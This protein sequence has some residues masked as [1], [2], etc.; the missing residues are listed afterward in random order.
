VPDVLLCERESSLL[1][2]SSGRNAAIFRPLELD[3]EITALVARSA[4][5][6][7]QLLGSRSEWLR[8]A[9][10]LFVARDSRS[11]DHLARAA[12]GTDVTLTPL[13]E[14]ELHE[15][16]PLLREGDARAGMAVAG[17]G[18]LDTHA[19]AT[20]LV[21]SF[22]AGGGTIRTGVDIV[23]IEQRHARVAGVR[24][25]S[26]ERLAC[27]V[28]VIA[29]GA[30]APELGRTSGCDLTLEIL[31]RH[32]VL[33]DGVEPPPTRTIWDVQQELYFRP[34]SGRVLA[35]PGDARRLPAP[36]YVASPRALALLV[37][38]ARGVAPPI[39]RA[40]VQRLWACLRVFARDG[41]PVIGEDPRVAG[42]H[43]IAG[44][45]GFGMSA[46]VAAGEVLARVVLRDRRREDE[47]FS[48]RRLGATRVARV[49]V[50]PR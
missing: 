9:G 2:M 43:W 39:A 46:G 19:I 15:Q 12:E 21:R 11:I 24:T 17:A 38:K 6:L 31:R 8:S 37:A 47:S 35:S 14:R 3:A 7:D 29:C 32:L 36:D 13:G 30:W 16:E 1:A 33:L 5:L 18:Q 42:L 20:A 25:V 40:H 28:A 27:R 44:L 45:G 49:R 26:G 4:V 48:P 41:Q 22:R 23:R 34:E 10:L 50:S